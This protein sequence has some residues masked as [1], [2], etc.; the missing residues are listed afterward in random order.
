MLTGGV[1]KSV[2]LFDRASEK[3]L[4]TLTG[5]TKKITSVLFHPKE[6]ILLSSSLDKTAR[7]WR[8]SEAGY[9]VVE[10][11]KA[12]VSGV[13]GLSLHASGD[14]VVTASQDASWAFHDL[15]NARCLAHVQNPDSSAQFTSVSFH[16]DG[17]ILG[18]GS[19]TNVVHIWDVK[20][21][22]NLATFEGH[23]G[24]I[25][26]IAFSENGFYLATASEDGSVRLWDLR[27]L[28]NV[29][30]HKFGKGVFADCLDFDYS[31]TYLATGGT[32]VNIFSAKSLDPIKTLSDHKS[33]T[34]LKFGL[35]SSFLATVA[36]DRFLKFFGR[37]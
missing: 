26:D 5:H 20:S 1:D 6:D 11:L 7:I 12:H 24:S 10:T 30:T 22:K 28:K 3:K 32:D 2:I 17:L 14:Y 19:S 21:Q 16:P 8:H 33:V 4:A 9:E 36:N 35:D 31:G 34:D 29:Q 23:E 37:S 13:I 27:K 15:H 18:T 25:T